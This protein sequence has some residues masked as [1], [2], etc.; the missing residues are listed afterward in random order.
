MHTVTND[1]KASWAILSGSVCCG[2]NKTAEIIKDYEADK[3]K[4]YI[5][6]QVEKA[7][8]FCSLQSQTQSTFA[9]AGTFCA[10]RSESVCLYR[11]FPRG[12]RR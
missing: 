5:L 6:S 2:N 11:L 12:I 1:V 7:S 9:R 10:Q 4:R 8:R 3:T